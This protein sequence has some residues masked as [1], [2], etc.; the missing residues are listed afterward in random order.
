MKKG[1][2]KTKKITKEKSGLG[3]QSKLAFKALKDLESKKPSKNLLEIDQ[4]HF[5]YMGI[6]LGQLP[7]A[8]KVHN[9]AIEVPNSIFAEDSKTESLF[10]VSNE[11]YAQNKEFLRSLRP[12]WRFI[13]YDK[14]K[15]N[16]KLYKD[17]RS[18]G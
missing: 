14:I 8:D 9:F 10:I 13:K 12:E 11:F 2:Q 7:K 5:L 17:K 15:K 3:S 1:N 4:D 6:T 18:L 16:F